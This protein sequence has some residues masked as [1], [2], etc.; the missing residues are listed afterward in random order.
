MIDQLGFSIVN[1]DI[2]NRN[3]VDCSDS[4]LSNKYFIR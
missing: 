3:V 2:T 4:D 1:I